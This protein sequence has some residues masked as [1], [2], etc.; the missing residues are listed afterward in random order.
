MI[1]TPKPAAPQ[2]ADHFAAGDAVPLKQAVKQLLQSKT[3]A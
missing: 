1:N 2:N 3:V